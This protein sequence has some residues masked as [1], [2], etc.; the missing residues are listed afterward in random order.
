MK[1]SFVII[2]ILI[3]SLSLFGCSLLGPNKLTFCGNVDSNLKP[4]N[5]STTFSPGIV[6]ALLNNGVSINTTEVEITIYVE[7][8][9]IESVFD[10][11]TIQ[12]NQNWGTIAKGI[13]FIIPGKYKVVFTRTS[14]QKELGEGIVTIQ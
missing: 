9:N 3:L 7:N 6:Y 5:P 4:I 8:G 1:K 12:T 13:Y 14:D 10:S 2:I 11:G